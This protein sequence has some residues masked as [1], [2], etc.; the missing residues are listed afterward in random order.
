MEHNKDFVDPS[1]SDNELES[2]L[3]T[4]EHENILGNPYRPKVLFRDL[5][6]PTFNQVDQSD[7][8]I[9]WHRFQKYLWLLPLPVFMMGMFSNV[10]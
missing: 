2:M 6:K 10:D 7:V 8:P 4:N 9:V 5:L 3:K 1:R